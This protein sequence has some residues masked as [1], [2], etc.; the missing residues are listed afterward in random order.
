MDYLI[1]DFFDYSFSNHYKISN[2]FCISTNQKVEEYFLNEKKLYIIGKIHGIYE[3]TFLRRFNKNKINNLLK[4][5][6]EEIKNKLEGEFLIILKNKNEVQ[7]VVI[8]IILAV[9]KTYTF[10]QHGLTHKCL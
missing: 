8:F 6:I 4:K 7:T 5:S 2:N 10:Y 9:L 1:T 3:E